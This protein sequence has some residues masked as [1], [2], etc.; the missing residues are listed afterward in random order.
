MSEIKEATQLFKMFSPISTQAWKE[1]IIADLKGADYSKRLVWRTQE[2]FNVEP[3]YRE[4]DLETLKYLLDCNPG[5]FPFVRGNKVENNDWLIRQNIDAADVKQAN[6]KALE[7]LNKGVESIG[8]VFAEGQKVTSS[9]FDTLLS[10]ICLDAI[11]T[12]FVAPHDAENIANLFVDYA[13]ANYKGKDLKVS[14]DFDPVGHFALYGKFC[15]N[16][17]DLFRKAGELV[18]NTAKYKECQVI[19]V[20]ANH[21]KNAGVN[22][23]QELGAALAMGNEYLARLTD[24]GFDAAAINSKMRFNFGVDVNYFMEIA[25]FRAARFLWARIVEKYG[26]EKQDCKMHIH[27]QTSTWGM[28]VYDPYVNTLRTTTSA[29]SATLGGVESLT[30]DPFNF[31][32]EPTPQSERIARNQQLILKEESYFK[33][34]VDPAGGSYYIE[35][36]THQLIQEAWELFLEF[37]NLGGFLSSYRKGHFQ[38]KLVQTVAERSKTIALRKETFLGTNDF[39]NFSET[40]E[41]M[42][43]QL[44]EAKD[45]TEADA[46]TKGLVTYRGP[47]EFERM[48]Y[49]TDVWAKNNKR[50]VVFMLTYGNLAMRLA[51]SQFSQNFFAI[52]GFTTIDNH[53]FKSMSE[54]VKAALD[55]NADIVVLCSSDDEYPAI[56]PEALGLLKG[57]AEVVVAGYPKDAMEQLQK[58]GIE[59]FIH[60]KSNVLET[61]EAFQKQLGLLK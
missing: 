42:P 8:F 18:H 52:G 41:N 46:E 6:Q 31:Y 51:R 54:G 13:D 15:S 45:N 60:V 53:G 23:V 1:K 2:G 10:K 35:N 3:F 49:R 57:K 21:F 11:E 4:E 55:H 37:E 19:T 7:V 32:E 47:Q 22:I 39:P 44:F 30:V 17:S 36:L 61:L 29:M 9:D 38:K 14:I 20:H 58:A 12:C 26:A 28:S 24:A 40:K 33:N 27:A 56:A 34:V 59:H 25:K 43:A 48:R 16:E 5:E 50:P